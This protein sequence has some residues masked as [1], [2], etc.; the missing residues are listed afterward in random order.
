M[1]KFGKIRRQQWIDFLQIS[2]ITESESESMITKEDVALK[3]AN[4]YRRLYGGRAQ[5][6]SPP[7]KRRLRRSFQWC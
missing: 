7:F 4:F 2:K 3:V 5:T 6:C 1:D